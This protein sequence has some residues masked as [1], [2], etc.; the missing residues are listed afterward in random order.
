MEHLDL[1]SGIGGFTL[2]FQRA[3]NFRT[4]AF[5]E[6]DKYC[7]KVLSHRWPN[8]RIIEDVRKVD[9]RE[10]DGID[11]ITGGFPCQ[12]VS[13]AG[14]RTGLDGERSGLWF[15]FER[16]IEEARPRWVVIENV[17]GLL[18][19]NGGRDFATIIRALGELRYG[20]VWRVLDSQ[21]FGVPQRRRRVFIVGH[22]GS[23]CAN[24]VLFEREGGRRDSSSGGEE[25]REA[26][27]TSTNRSK[28]DR[29]NGPGKAISINPR[30]YLVYDEVATT[31]QSKST[32][33]WSLNY[34]PVV[35]YW[36]GTQTVDT[37]DTSQ[38]LKQQMMPEKRRF[39]VVWEMSHAS[40]VVREHEDVLPTLNRRMGTGGNQ[41]PLIGLRRLTPTECCRA[42]GFPDDWNAMCSDSQ[43]YKQLGN[44]VTVNVIQWIAERILNVD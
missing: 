3:G 9:G 40:E 41:V 21:Y 5:V 17:P 27:G 20:V 19:S 7:Q 32:G 36:D 30:N 44:A 42:Q 33:G 10:F 8:T 25:E 13:V 16:I 34:M 39:P 11:I 14:A 35:A 18:Q 2:G 29:G 43:R 6:Q 28:D 31:L 22:L 12:D 1:F 23:T 26:T 24:E 37:L 4:V 38:L 15:E